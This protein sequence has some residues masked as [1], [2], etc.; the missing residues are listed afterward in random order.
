MVS[1]RQPTKPKS[2]ALLMATTSGTKMQPGYILYSVCVCV[3]VCVRNRGGGLPVK[4]YSEH[5]SLF[6]CVLVFEKGEMF[7]STYRKCLCV[8]SS[9]TQGE[10]WR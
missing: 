10:E 8:C 7:V 4:M 3:F 1:I 2:S 9:P 6:M 5:V